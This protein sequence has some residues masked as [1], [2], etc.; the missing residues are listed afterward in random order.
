MVGL[1]H[2]QCHFLHHKTIEEMGI[3]EE[4]LTMMVNLDFMR[5]F[6]A[7]YLVYHTTTMKFLS[8]LEVQ[9]ENETPSL[10]R[11]Q[12]G[13]T[14][15]TLTPNELNELIHGPE[16]GYY[17]EDHSFNAQNLWKKLVVIEED[18]LKFYNPSY[19]NVLSIWN[20]AF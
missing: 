20:P 3:D 13:N 7:D 12:L 14:S 11:F 4:V 16:D 6:H 2:K 17:V 18:R 10:L 8:T 19:A 15:R 1:K 9:R 5:I